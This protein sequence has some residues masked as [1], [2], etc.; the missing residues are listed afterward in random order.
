MNQTHGLYNGP[1]STTFTVATLKVILLLSNITKD[2]GIRSIYYGI[3]VLQDCSHRDW[4]WMARR[5]SITS[6]E[7]SVFLLVSL[8]L[9]WTKRERVL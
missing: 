7:V 3:A 5:S 4:C 8:G 6:T 1:I 9:R 2:V